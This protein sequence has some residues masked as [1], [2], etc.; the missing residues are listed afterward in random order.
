MAGAA[1]GQA[2][3]FSAEARGVPDDRVVRARPA[4]MSVLLAITPWAAEAGV[5]SCEIVPTMRQDH[6]VAG[7]PM[8]RIRS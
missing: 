3:A 2:H 7:I 6:R 1:S 5:T 8:R 4:F